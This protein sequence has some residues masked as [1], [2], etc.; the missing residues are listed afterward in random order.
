MADDVIFLQ[1]TDATIVVTEPD[2]EVLIIAGNGGSGPTGPQ[3][4]PGPSGGV[5]VIHVQST[6]S[7]AWVINHNL[8]TLVHVTILNNANTVVD[9]EVIESTVN[10]VVINFNTAQ[11]GTAI[12]SA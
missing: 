5:P 7:A 11:T 12:V 1:P 4:P 8:G 2:P 9:A 6:P 10:T 3:G